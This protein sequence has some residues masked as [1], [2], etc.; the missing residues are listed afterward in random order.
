MLNHEEQKEV[1]S[2][3]KST[4]GLIYKELETAQITE[5]GAADY[6][7]N[8]DFAVQEFLKQELYIRFPGLPMIAEE[9]ENKELSAAG[10]YWILDPIDGTT[11]LIHH[12]G[13]SAVALALYEA[14][15]ITFGAVYNPFHEELFYAAK[16][17][18]AYLNGQ[19]IFAE[20]A[21]KW[22]DAVVAYGS[23]PYEKKR[24]EKL[25]P[26]FHKIFLETADFRRTGSAELDLCYIAC[27]RQHAY[28]EQDLKP[29]DYAAGSLILREAGG[30]VNRWDGSALPYLENA[31]VAAS[32][33]SL[34]ETFLKMLSEQ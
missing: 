23:S 18:G 22:K 9:K 26:L 10:R 5:K 31:D 29:W 7:T 19:R 34:Y 12:Y 25:F 33:K 4:K 17:E 2:L 1:L 24:A 15:E 28:I 32:T 11:N 21:V 14:G 16:G 8:V 27:G 13:I 3:I 6:V 30:R 20:D